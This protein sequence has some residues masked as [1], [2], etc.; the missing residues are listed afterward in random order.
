MIELFEKLTAPISVLMEKK[1]KVLE[2]DFALFNSL[3]KILKDQ[4]KETY[5]CSGH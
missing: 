4:G 2:I 3:G 1:K 5:L